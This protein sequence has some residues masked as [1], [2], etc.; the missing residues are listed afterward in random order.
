MK[1]LLDRAPRTVFTATLIHASLKLVKLA[2]YLKA[3][4]ISQR[5]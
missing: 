2:N 1:A 4:Y 5:R 3:E